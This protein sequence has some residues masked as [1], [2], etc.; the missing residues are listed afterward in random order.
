MSGIRNR[1]KVIKLVRI[2][3]VPVSLKLLLRGQ[4][5]FMKSNGLEVT[6]ISSSGPE[7][8]EVTGFENCRHVIVPL[9]RTI[10]VFQDLQ[11]L[12]RLTILLYKLKPDIVHTHTPKAGLVGMWAAAIVGV[13]VR[14]HTIAGLPFMT[15]SGL[16]RGVLIAAERLTYLPAQFVLPNSK[17][18]RQYM[19]DNKLINPKKL[20]LIGHGSS[21][22]I[23]IS[24]YNNEVLDQNKLDNIKSKI[25][26]SDNLMYFLVVGRMVKDKG[27]NEVITSFLELSN[28]YSHV[29]LILL[30]PFEDLRKEESLSEELRNIIRENNK[31]TH[32][33]WSNHVE[34]FMNISH[35]LIHASHREGFPNVLLQAGAMNCP[36]ICSDIPGNIDIVKDGNTGVLFSKGD[37]QNLIIKMDYSI[38]NY[39]DLI[40]Y[41]ANL[42]VIVKEN[43][44]SSTI[45]KELLKLYNELV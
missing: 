18:I 5:K 24:R 8:D 37:I 15:S 17:S 44:S 22:G 45:H 27:V 40:G 25:G 1:I 29:R 43:F 36:I 19:I 2:T 16:K 26:Y 21:N 31:I 23:D 13:K 39:I 10:S 33:K 38:N 28:L 9:T 32:I 14:L 41:A 30:G 11:S 42:N 7:V 4:M 12:F 6:M 35:I 3:T 20:R 34:Y